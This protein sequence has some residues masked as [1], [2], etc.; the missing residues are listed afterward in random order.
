ME[1]RIIDD[2]YG[3]GIRMKKNKDGEVDV[4]DAA[5][6]ETDEFAEGTEEEVLFEFPDLQED[7]EELAT[8]TPEEALELKKRRAEEAKRRAE[9]YERL[10]TEGEA[11]TQAEDYEAAVEAYKKAA[12]L[13]AEPAEAIIGYW[14]AR[15]AGYTDA[16]VLYAAYAD[17]G[18][19]EFL[20]D[21]GEEAAEAVKNG[22]FAVVSERLAALKTEGE[23]LEKE[24]GEKQESRRKVI[25][26]RL[27][28]ARI[29]FFA[30]AIPTLV[31]LV[32][33]IYFGVSINT[34]PDRLYLWF[35]IGG[36]AL[37]LI[38]F[39]FFCAAANTYYNACRINRKNERLSSTEEG[40]QLLAIRKR[41]AFFEALLA[42]ELKEFE[43]EEE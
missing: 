6:P 38:S 20:Y 31:L 21:V 35:T 36:A 32:L 24:V 25:K 34:R 18:F 22:L 13:T 43:P 30:A 37:F 27:S 23:P 8:L 1:E 5:A 33:T 41:L 14:R 17:G 7:D 3:R 28:S 10:M 19:D 12:E 42:F 29:G 15:T 2:E 16:D 26:K 39:I 11:L 4:T 9:E 40:K